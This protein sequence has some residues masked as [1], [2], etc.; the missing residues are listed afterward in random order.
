MPES[1]FFGHIKGIRVGEVFKDR[2]TLNQK[3]LHSQEQYGI[4]GR[5]DEGACAIVL[6]GGYEDDE[7]NLD[8]VLYTGQG[9]REKGS[10]FQTFNQ[11]FTRG[12]EALRLSHIY[13]KP[14]RLIRGYQVEYGPSFGYRYDGLY[15]VT[16][17]DYV[18]GKSG[19]MVCRF[20]LVSEEKFEDL[21]SK[22]LET[23][24]EENT[25]ASR[26]NIS[27]ER[28]IR[29]SKLAENVKRRYDHSCQI[30]NV[31]L[32]SP[33]GPISIAAHIQGLGR[34]HNGPDIESNMLCLCPNHHD[35]FDKYAFY[36]DPKNF[37][38]VGLDDYVGEKITLK[39][40]INSEFLE[41]QKIL[42]LN[43]QKN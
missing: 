11:E 43:H 13:E 9:G 15:Y 29:N 30:C 34:P 35:Q 21:R 25:P 8:E 14:V 19:F 17:V 16:Q 42:F 6:S 1:L 38:I 31:Q 24:K 2:A 12:N 28:I 41:Y 39:H 10:R 37:H 36:I 33:L 26:K 40:K 22:L 4:N 18:R 3:K 7:D 32:S 20:K 5:Q 27:S 23:F